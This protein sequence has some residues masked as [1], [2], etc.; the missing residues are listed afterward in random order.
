MIFAAYM[1]NHSKNE[2]LANHMNMNNTIH[3]FM[4]LFIGNILKWWY[5][6]NNTATYT[7][8]MLSNGQIMKHS[9]NIELIKILIMQ[10]YLYKYGTIRSMQFSD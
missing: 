3:Y 10:N 1:L 6:F 5:I 2:F 4:K 9:Y 8:K 7:F